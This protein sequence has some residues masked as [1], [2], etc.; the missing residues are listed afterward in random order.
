MLVEVQ[1]EQMHRTTLYKILAAKTKEKKLGSG[2]AKVFVNTHR[3][4]DDDMP[5][6]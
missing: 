2:R 5:E 6:L 1:K 3:T 4:M